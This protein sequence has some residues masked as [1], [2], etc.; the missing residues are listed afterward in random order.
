[1]IE[2][3]AEAPKIIVPLFART[4]P[5]LTAQAAAAQRADAAD[6]VELRLDPLPSSHTVRPGMSSS[7]QRPV[8][9]TW[10]VSSRPR[11][12]TRAMKRLG[13][14]RKTARSMC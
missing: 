5:E 9:L 6:L 4:L 12:S 7:R 14:A 3:H 8:F 2:L 11:S 1:M 10:T 13:R